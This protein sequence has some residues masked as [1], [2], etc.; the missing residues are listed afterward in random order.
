MAG[1]EE[2]EVGGQGGVEARVGA[3]AAVGLAGVRLKVLAF[4]GGGGR[5]GW[6][7]GGG[8]GCRG[9]EA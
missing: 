9:A 6:V 3:E 5:A 7:V 8:R 1:S 2:G 4:G